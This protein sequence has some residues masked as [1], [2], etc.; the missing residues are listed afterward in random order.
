MLGIGALFEVVV[1]RFSV[2]SSGVIYLAYLATKL[3]LQGLLGI[4]VFFALAYL[5]RLAP[6]GEYARMLGGVLQY[7]FPKIAS[8]IERRFAI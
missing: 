8:A 2:S 5:F 3:M 7:R 4:T 6:L 1:S